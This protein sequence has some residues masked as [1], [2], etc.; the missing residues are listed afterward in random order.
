[1]LGAGVVRDFYR[2]STKGELRMIRKVLTAFLMLAIGAPDL[3][4]AVFPPDNWSGIADSRRIN[5]SRAGAFRPDGTPGIPSDSW[6]QCGPTIAAG[7]SASTIQSAIDSCGANQYVQLGAGIFNLSTGLRM[8]S[9]VVL[10][11]MGADQTIM[12]FS[13]Y[14]GC[15]GEF[16]AAVCFQGGDTSDYF[17][18]SKMQPGNSN[19]ALWTGGYAQGST[20]ITLSNIGSSGLRQGQYI[21]LDQANE[22]ARNND[23]YI[24]ETSG[25]CSLEGGSG[26]P[27]RV[28]GG[29]A[30]QHVQIVK[31]VN[32]GAA[33]AGGACTSNNLT[34]DPGLYAPNWNASKSPGAYWPSSSI[35][36]A[37]VENLSIDTTSSGSR[38]NVSFYNA[39]NVWVKGTR[40]IKSC[41]CQ[42]RLIALAQTTRATIQDNYFYGMQGHSVHYGVESYV[43][44]DS[45][46]INNIFQHTDGPITMHACIGSVF[47]Y[48]YSIHNTY[49]DGRSP[50]FH[51]MNPGIIGHSGGVLY[52]LFEGNNSQGVNGDFY[53]GNQ[54]MNTAFRN[55]FRGHD[56]N[57]IDNLHAVKLNTGARYWNIVGNVLGTP[58]VTQGYESPYPDVYSL[59]DGY[60]A[61]LADDPFVATTLLRWGNWDVVTNGTRWSASEVPS[62]LSLYANPVPVSQSLPASLFLASRPSW[63]PSAKPWPPIGP[64]V[65]GGNIS[66]LAGRAYTVPAQDCYSNVMNGPANGIGSPLSFNAGVCYPTGPVTP[67]APVIVAQP[68]NQTVIV[69]QT[70]TFGVAATG[71]PEPTYQWQQLPVGGSWTA[72]A[73]ATNSSY[74]TAATTLAYSGIKYRVT[75]TNSQGS[76]T[77]DGTAT[78]TVTEPP[79][80]KF[81]IGDRV[82]IV[83]VVPPDV[84]NI[85]SAASGGTKVGTQPL[86]ALGTVVGGPTENGNGIWWNVNF[87]TGADGWDTEPYLDLASP[88]PHP[89][90]R[91]PQD[92]KISLN[93]ATSY[94][95]CWRS[96]PSIPVGC[97]TPTASLDN[98]VRAGSLWN[99]SATGDYRFNSGFACPQCWEAGP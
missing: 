12:N 20:Q 92:W 7:A 90:D 71:Y 39:V 41:D 58:G 96:A 4:W 5:W 59:G 21:Y 31:I 79:P 49:D 1:M 84:A 72:I 10:R 40:Q 86:N 69:G 22:T 16:S 48:N 82:K 68:S 13:G 14:N 6:T 26:N 78:L 95:A 19:A 89:A 93:E 37:G 44:S 9:N 60:G 29:V 11:G 46:I 57:R 50:Q 30:R 27:G 45:L 51:W 64:D 25:E 83:G 33:S 17:A 76:V 80:A 70:A 91:N 54:V 63:W 66:G 24:C 56:P 36:N 94:G 87:D 43:A 73:N 42:R 38:S 52:N 18:S 97:P 32:C 98:A 65:S 77:S 74:T 28:V 62:G 35:Q 15:T 34:I 85:W 47:A 61:T 23:L 55:Y 75:V 8:K 2:F 67:S 88:A 53:H 81:R 3:S 99:A